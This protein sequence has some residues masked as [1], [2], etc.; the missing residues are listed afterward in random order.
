MDCIVDRAPAIREAT[1]PAGKTLRLLI[2][3][4]GRRVGLLR[5][6]QRGAAECGVTLE[7]L[8]CDISPDWSAACQLADRAFAVPSAVDPHYA[9]AIHAICEDYQVGL[10]VPTID[11][12]LGPLSA[13]AADFAAIGTFLAISDANVIAIA[14]DKLAT[15]NT[16]LRAGIRTPRSAPLNL[17][18]D[19]PDEWMWPLIVKPRSGSAGRAV[20]VIQ[21]PEDLDHVD[22][23]PMM[24]QE[25]LHGSEWTVNLFVDRGGTLRAIIPHRRVTIRSGEVEKGVTER[26][27][28]LEDMARRLVGCL[29]GMRGV[30]CFQAIVAPDGTASIFEIN[31]RFG[32]GYPLADHAGANFGRWLIEERCGLESTASN[33]WRSGVTML[34]FDDAVFL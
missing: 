2:T 4:A 27:P 15:A 23:E 7:V 22:D 13:C 18:R 29:P 1:P 19:H 10:V 6:F 21:R 28:V 34:R 20:R 30:L 33:I 9:R 25:R 26:M 16:L 3:S 12:E 17:V 5:A 11:P 14:G 24:A 32:G 8:A 31:A